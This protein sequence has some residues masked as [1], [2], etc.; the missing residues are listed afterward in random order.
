MNFT[1]LMAIAAAGCLA[2]APVA[3]EAGTR[4]SA[5]SGH[6]SFSAQPAPSGTSGNQSPAVRSNSSR[7]DG[8][9]GAAYDDD[10]GLGYVVKHHRRF[11]Y[12]ALAAI[13]LGALGIGLTASSQSNG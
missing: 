11:P 12:W 9:D 10:D 7:D 8:D 13:A 5:F 2:I 6:A 3:A 1:H 4:A